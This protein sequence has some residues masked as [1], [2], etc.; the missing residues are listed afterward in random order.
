MAEK[1]GKVLAIKEFFADSTRPLEN[2]ELLKLRKEDPDGFDEIA[3]LCA[4]A[5]GKEI[6]AK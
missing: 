4:K 3:G 5:I 6:E 2:S 1:I